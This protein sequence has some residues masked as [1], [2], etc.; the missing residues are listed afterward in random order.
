MIKLFIYILFPLLLITSNK[1]Q[2]EECKSDKLLRVALL[3]NSYIDYKYYLLYTLNDFSFQNNLKFEFSY[4]EDNPNEFDIIFGE[5]YDLQKMVQKEIEIPTDLINFYRKNGISISNNIFPLDLD[6]F[7]LASKQNIEMVSLEELSKISSTTYYTLGLSFLPEEK[8]INFISD[9]FEG[10]EFEN[11]SVNYESKFTLLRENYKNVNKNILQSN[12]EEIYNSYE[13]S[14]NLFTLFSDGII[15]YKGFEFET[16]YRVPKSKYSWDEKDGFF[17]IKDNFESKSFF[18]FSA[19]L[20]N[21][22]QSSFLCYLTQ[23]ENR[24]NAFRNFNIELSPLSE[25][26]ILPIKDLISEK[27]I[28]LL[29]N[30]NQNIVK[31]DYLNYV[32]NHKSY[33]DLISNKKDFDEM[34]KDKNYLN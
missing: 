23:E 2:T 32:K 17:K 29:K 34:Y 8:L 9:I 24:L 12:F 6:T 7:I 3:E 33:I 20:N 5:H 22:S 27:Y 25:N 18:G 10:D 11:Y 16:Y 19:Y 31:L 26:E 1:A 21:S 30:K 13:N 15:L 4:Y 28:E 14:E